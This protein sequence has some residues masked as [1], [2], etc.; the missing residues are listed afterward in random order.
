M[1]PG[2]VVKQSVAAHKGTIIVSS[3]KHQGTNLTVC[4]PLRLRLQM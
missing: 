3:Q 2:S 4:L 1:A